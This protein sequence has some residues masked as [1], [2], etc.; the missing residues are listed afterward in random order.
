MERPARAIRAHAKG[1]KSLERLPCGRRAIVADG[2]IV[3]T[4]AVIVK[5][6]CSRNHSA[7]SDRTLAYCPKKSKQLVPKRFGGLYDW[8]NQPPHSKT[9]RNYLIKT[10]SIRAT[11]A[12]V[13]RT[14]SFI[15]SAGI[16]SHTKLLKLSSRQESRLP[17]AGAFPSRRL[18]KEKPF[19]S[20]A[21]RSS[22]GLSSH[23]T[24]LRSSRQESNL[25]RLLRREKSYPLN[26]ER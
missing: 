13:L 21:P 9:A 19:D 17:C 26:D 1:S 14:N 6:F 2:N 4:V 23:Y 16:E 3:V 11:N 24:S 10:L 25:Y 15:L 22:A 5:P 8:P 12:R 7:N 20:C 18:D